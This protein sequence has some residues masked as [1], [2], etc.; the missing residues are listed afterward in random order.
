[1]IDSRSSLTSAAASSSFLAGIEQ[2]ALH[3][4]LVAAK[5]RR[6]SAKHNIT[7]GGR[8]ASHLFLVRSGRV[9]YYHLTKQGESVLL[10]WMVPGDVIGLMA[11]LKTPSAYMATAEAISDC[12]LLV[13]ERSVIRKLVSRYPALGE[14]GLRLALGHLQKYVERHVGLVTKTAEERLSETLLNLGEQAGEV[15]PDGIEIHATNDELGALADVSPF[16]AS[17]VL[18]N[19]ARAGVLSKGRGRVLLRAPEALMVD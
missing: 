12:E 19:W 8:Q 3:A 11:L 4:I 15:H 7:T 9:H 17:R 14:N 10:A 6:I 5:I 2:P 18:S 13:W 16:T 1:M